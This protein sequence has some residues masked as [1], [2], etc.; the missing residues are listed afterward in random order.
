MLRRF[1]GFAVLF[2][3]LVCSSPPCLAEDAWGYFWNFGTNR[4]HPLSTPSVTVGR[5]A[6]NNLVLRESRVSRH[7]AEIQRTEEG[8]VLVDQGSTNGTRLNGEKVVPGREYPLSQGDVVIFAFERLVF[9]E[10]LDRL[11]GD[12]FEK[13]LVGSFVRLNVPILADRTV[14]S[15][16]QERLIE[17]VS[18]ARVDT[19]DQTVQMSYSERIKGQV[20]FEPGETV[21]LANA[22]IEDGEVLLS[23]WG[24]QRGGSMVSRR[25]S[26]SRMKHGE[27]RVG[28]TGPSKRESRQLFQSRWESDGALFAFPLLRSVLER[29]ETKAAP[30]A[31][32]MTRSLLDQD[33]VVAPRDAARCF[34]VLHAL[35]PDET[36]IPALAALAT[37]MWVRRQAHSRRAILSEEERAELA[38]ELSGGKRWLEEAIELDARKKDIEKA[39][40]E[41][42]EAEKELSKAS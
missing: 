37:G 35:Y 7:H 8:V 32:K 41:I 31:L 24:L 21:F 30:V 1:F 17:A 27:L 23:L 18:E 33:G 6:R 36:D 3:L 10:S 11:W 5:S 16:G 28:L 25:A 38:S 22:S 29:L 13:S 40:R 39:R 19:D 9:H 15:L 12:V 26:F 34:E 4:L 2:G 14:K 42:A 20:G